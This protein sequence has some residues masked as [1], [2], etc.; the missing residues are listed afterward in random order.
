VLRVKINDITFV[1][2]NITHF[3]FHQKGFATHEAGATC[4]AYSSNKQFLISGGKKGEIGKFI[5]SFDMNKS[6]INFNFF[7][8][9]FSNI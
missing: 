5:S 9:K 6:S 7:F 8:T 2:N 1:L 4:L 3:F